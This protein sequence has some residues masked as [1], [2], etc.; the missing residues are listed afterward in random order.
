MKASELIERAIEILEAS[1]AIDH[2]QKDRELIE[3]EDLL[4][5]VMGGEEPEPDEDVPEGARRRFES[6]VARRATGEP[7]PFI[8]GYAEFRGIDLIAR[9]GVF[10]PRD[11]S[12]FLAEQAVR[13][14]R[15]RRR[16]VAVDLAT[17]GGTIALAIANE[18]PKAEV[19]GADVSTE[20]VK[21]ARANAR[22]LGLRASFGVGDLF[23]GLPRRLRST[24]DVITLHPPYVPRGEVRHLPDEIRDWEP[25]HTLTDNSV[26]GM[27]LV[28]RAVAEGPDWLRSDGWLLME[29]SPDRSREVM[30][31]YR[32]GGF[33]EVRSTK[34]GDLKVT[35]VIVGRRPS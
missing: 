34:G 14:L 13:R 33:R 25:A 28:H 9:P 12:E 19:F 24:V 18:V 6:M 16:P 20:A 26:D 23:G 10:V 2:W 7:I 15:A 3:A 31:I 4:M 22:R 21:L 29:V 30:A 35:R 8:K 27:G 32:R 5:H 17:G 11:S 1:D